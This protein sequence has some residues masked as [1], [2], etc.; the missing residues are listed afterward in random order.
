MSNLTH[1]RGE[2]LV[3]GEILFD[4]FPDGNAVLGGAPFNVAWHLRGFGMSPHLASAIGRDENGKQVIA[5]MGAWQLD[6]HGVRVHEKWPTGQVTI[7]LEDGDASF[8]IRP[9]QAYD[10]I[11]AND[12]GRIIDD[13]S[14]SMLYHGSLIV[15]G[16]HN[17]GVLQELTGGTNLPVF[18]DINLRAPWWDQAT[19]VQLLRQARW[20]K[21]NDDE[22]TALVPSTGT[23]REALINT[24]LKL[25]DQ[26]SLEMLIVTLGAQGA[27]ICT[28]SGVDDLPAPTPGK[29]VDTV[30]A[31]DAFSSVAIYGLHQGWS[32]ERIL[33]HALNFASVICEQRGATAMDRDLYTEKIFQT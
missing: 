25:R 4:I 32:P 29:I 18:M 10:F 24:A 26:Y 6:P 3:F 23:T 2:P 15:R 31:G 12:L 22:L 30:G 14:I 11:D 21:L 19:V 1:L 16:D 7:T 33:E 8:N 20:V 5:A 17:R 9:D 13:H 28:D 27:F